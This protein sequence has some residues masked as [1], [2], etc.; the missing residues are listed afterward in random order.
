[1]QDQHQDYYGISGEIFDSSSI[2]AVFALSCGVLLLSD[3]SCGVML[4]S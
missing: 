2:M 3:F 4:L 1:M